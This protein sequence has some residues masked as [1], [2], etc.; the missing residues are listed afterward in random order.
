MVD[1]NSD[2]IL[3]LIKDL[4]GMDPKV[5]RN[6]NKN[7]KN[8]A[9]S[10]AEEA[11]SNASW[12][13]R[14]PAA[15]KVRASRSRRFPGAEIYVRHADAPHARPYEHGSGRRRDS[16]RHP[17]Y[18]REGRPNVWVEQATR[19]FVRPAFKRKGF[20]FTHACNRAVNDAAREAGF[21]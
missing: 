11:R 19:P 9:E 17:V 3:G 10:V 12:S 5:R 8:A 15:I 21:R 6:L 18:Q 16:F 4:Q 20:E 13:T 2:D 7:F 1:R 14:I